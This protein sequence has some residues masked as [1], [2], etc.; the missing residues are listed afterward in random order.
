MPGPRGR[1]ADTAAAIAY[2]ASDDA[3]F[4]QGTELI[5]DG[6]RLGEL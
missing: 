4:V 5:I 6:G 2:L 1:P 3:V